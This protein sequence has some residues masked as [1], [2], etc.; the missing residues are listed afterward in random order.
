MPQFAIDAPSIIVA[1]IDDPPTIGKGTGNLIVSRPWP[2]AE[3]GLIVTPPPMNIDELATGSLGIC[4]TVNPKTML[5][6]LAVFVMLPV[7][8]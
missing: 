1:R 8:A 4:R 7:T 6:G 5:H 3:A 2:I